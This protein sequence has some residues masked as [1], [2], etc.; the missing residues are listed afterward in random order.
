MDGFNND[1]NGRCF[2]LGYILS[3]HCREEGGIGLNIPDDQEISRGPRDVLRAKPEGHL[4]GRG[5]S[6]GRRGCSRP[7]SHY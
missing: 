3:V 6:R 5:K 1:E 2:E 7:F 4:N